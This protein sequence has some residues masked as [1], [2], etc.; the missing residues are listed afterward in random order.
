VALSVEAFLNIGLLVIVG[1]LFLGQRLPV[2][3]EDNINERA[4]TNSHGAFVSVA[5]LLPLPVGFPHQHQGSA[6]QRGFVQGHIYWHP[7]DTEQTAKHVPLK[8]EHL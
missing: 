7:H 3:K 5:G 4:P 1:L 6:R 8:W 2:W